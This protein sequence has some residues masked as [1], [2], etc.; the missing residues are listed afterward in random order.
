[1]KYREITFQELRAFFKRERLAHPDLTMNERSHLGEL[2]SDE[3]EE[4][5]TMA[6]IYGII[7]TLT[8]TVV[9]YCTT[10]SYDKSIASSIYIGRDYRNKGLASQILN[11]LKIKRLCCLTDNENAIRLYEGLGFQRKHSTPHAIRFEREIT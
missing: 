9:G 10:P 3:D 1:M 5:F 7:D 4:S 6:S 11:S 8:N 2:S